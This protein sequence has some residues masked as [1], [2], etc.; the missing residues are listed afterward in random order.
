MDFFFLLVF[1][2]TTWLIFQFS[3]SFSLDLG[4]LDPNFPPPQG[5]GK[6]TT[7]VQVQGGGF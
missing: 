7:L 2:G 6:I 3:P 5:F 1:Y 4:K